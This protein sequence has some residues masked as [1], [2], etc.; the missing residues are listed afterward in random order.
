MKLKKKR[1]CANFASYQHKNFAGFLVSVRKA[2]ANKYYKEQF[3]LL[4]A[5]VDIFFSKSKYE[6]V[7]ICYM[8]LM[9]RLRSV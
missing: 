9:M 1:A 2:S 4:N 5:N 8:I 3:I 6:K 7:K